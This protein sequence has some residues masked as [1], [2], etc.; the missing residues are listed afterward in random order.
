MK[1]GNPRRLTVSDRIEVRATRIQLKNNKNP[2]W[3]TELDRELEGVGSG[4]GSSSGEE[5]GQCF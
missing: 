5:A 1:S 2:W 4:S 3:Q